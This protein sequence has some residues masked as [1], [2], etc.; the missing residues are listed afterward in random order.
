MSVIFIAV[1]KLKDR[2]H[3]PS[4][5]L[6]AEADTCIRCKKCTASCPMSLDVQ[7]MVGRSAMQEPECIV[8]GNCAD[9]CPNGAVRLAWTWKQ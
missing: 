2:L 3:L 9:T 8:C 1:T 7:G 4:L 6:E 5:H